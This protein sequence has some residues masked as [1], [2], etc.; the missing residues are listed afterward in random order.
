[1]VLTS[2]QS[3]V[4]RYLSTKDAEQ[5]KRA[6]WMDVA[7]SI[8]WA[9][10]VFLL[11]TA[12]F[13]F[14]RTHPQSL[15]PSMTTD[16]IVPWFI[17]QNVPIGLSGLIIAGIFAAAMSSMDSSMH[18]VSTLLVTDFYARFVPGSTDH[19]RLKLARWIT[20]TL[21]IFGTCAALWMA[22]LNVKSLWDVFIKF[23]GLFAGAVGGLFILG[24][25][26]R[27]CNGAGALVGAV[28]SAAILFWVKSETH[29]HVLMYGAVGLGSCV[30]VGYLAS[31]VLPGRAK[32]EG[33]TVYSGM[34]EG[35]PAS[36]RL[37]MENSKGRTLK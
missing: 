24:I 14:Y 15:D 13:V 2:D 28:A 19:R 7:A 34:K 1:M 25:F 4:Q 6:L 9:V 10:V 33:L 26:T 21:G 23:T 11:G 32:C 22:S 30:I 3:T 37:A 20:V 29:L 35:R 31:L 27:R 16:Q 5:A 17:V 18:S 36:D 8:P 12:L